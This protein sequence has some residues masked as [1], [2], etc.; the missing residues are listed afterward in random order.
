MR[1]QR[2]IWYGGILAFIYLL[3]VFG[4]LTAALAEGDLLNITQA[5]SSSTLIQSSTHVATVTLYLTPSPSMTRTPTLLFCDP[6]ADWTAITILPGDTLDSLAELYRSTAIT[7]SNANCLDESKITPGMVFFV[8]RI[9]EPE[10]STPT[11]TQ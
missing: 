2:Q 9:Q 5:I 1:W 7:L 6:P 11:Q 10:A 8:P 3:L 4:S